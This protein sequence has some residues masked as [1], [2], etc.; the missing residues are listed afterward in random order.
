MKTK[1]TRGR[2]SFLH[3]GDEGSETASLGQGQICDEDNREVFI[4]GLVTMEMAG[5]VVASVRGLDRTRGLIKILIMSSGGHEGAGWAI[6]D[7]IKLCKNKTVIEAYGECQS[8]C[9]LILQAAKKRLLA[10]H[11][12]LMIHDGSLSFSGTI[13]QMKS[14]SKEAVYLTDMYYEALATGSGRSVHTIK[15]LCN[16][17]TFMSAQEAV[18]FGFA[19]G[20]LG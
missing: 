19:D 6:F 2:G 17:E 20:I 13:P 10:R 14:S 12:R 9:A 1:K 3:H 8:I 18:D 15:K 5:A 4:I 11:C 16:E 7:A